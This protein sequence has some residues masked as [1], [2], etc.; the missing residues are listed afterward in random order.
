MW[1]L[2]IFIFKLFYYLLYYMVLYIIYL[3]EL[4]V[5]ILSFSE[6]FVL[7][8]SR[9]DGEGNKNY[10]LLFL[11]NYDDEFRFPYEIGPGE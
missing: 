4:F 3:L 5:L 1:F 6:V 9:N 2:L 8:S 11:L 7:F 10:F